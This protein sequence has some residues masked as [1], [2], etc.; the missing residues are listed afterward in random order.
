MVLSSYDMRAVETLV[1]FREHGLLK[2]KL[3]LVPLL[4][5]LAFSWP[6]ALAFLTRVLCW[7]AVLVFKSD[8]AFRTIFFEPNSSQ[9][10]KA[11]L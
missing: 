9:A 7:L 6:F 3:A 5:Q 10:F 2:D 11:S 1:M 4:G 8:F